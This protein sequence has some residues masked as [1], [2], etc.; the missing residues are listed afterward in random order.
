MKSD[1]N[2]RQA[3]KTLKLF[4][5]WI[6]YNGICASLSSCG[7]DI[8]LPLLYIYFKPNLMMYIFFLI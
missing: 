7:G 2:L 8:N 4:D 3:A 6:G 1:K 5:A